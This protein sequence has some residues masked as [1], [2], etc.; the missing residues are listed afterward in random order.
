MNVAS[1]AVSKPLIINSAESTENNKPMRAAK[2]FGPALIGSFL[3]LSV[4]LT[5]FEK[6]ARILY[7]GFG[8]DRAKKSIIKNMS[9]RIE[10]VNPEMITIK[11]V[12]R[13]F[14]RAIFS[15][16]LWKEIGQKTVDDI[17][18]SF[19]KLILQN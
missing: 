12:N 9:G 2:I 18:F 8:I 10:P 4:L 17:L 7:A 13:P 19:N 5:H 14:R 15:S 16:I 6:I 3:N 11:V 1:A